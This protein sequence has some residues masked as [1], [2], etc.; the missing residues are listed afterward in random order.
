MASFHRNKKS[1]VNTILLCGLRAC[2]VLTRAWRWSVVCTG[3]G[4]CRIHRA[5]HNN[6][7]WVVR[8][9]PLLKNKQNMSEMGPQLTSGKYDE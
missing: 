5:V 3:R 8:G 7:L 9:D 4:V 6:S 2:T 1:L